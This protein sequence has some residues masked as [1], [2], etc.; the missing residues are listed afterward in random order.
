MYMLPAIE[1]AH[2]RFELQEKVTISPRLRA[3]A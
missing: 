3:A 2:R 1:A